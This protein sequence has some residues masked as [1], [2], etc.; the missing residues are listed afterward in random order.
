MLKEFFVKTGILYRTR[1]V[2]QDNYRKKLETLNQIVKVVFTN[3]IFMKY[4]DVV[5]LFPPYKPINSTLH[6]NGQ[7]YQSN[8]CH[9]HSL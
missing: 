4:T 8:V 6:I 7:L 3:S 5:G 9:I 1:S 2:I